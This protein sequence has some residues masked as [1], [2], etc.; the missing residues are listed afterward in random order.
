MLQLY[1]DVHA[2]Q[3][4]VW[5]GHLPAENTG[6]IT[7]PHI[8]SL[9]HNGWSGWINFELVNEKFDNRKVTI[10]SGYMNW[11]KTILYNVIVANSNFCFMYTFT[12]FSLIGLA[13]YFSQSKSRSSKCPN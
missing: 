13:P 2:Q 11:S 8:Q 9:A 6:C 7:I 4:Y 5:A 10:M 12:I 3:Q 1:L